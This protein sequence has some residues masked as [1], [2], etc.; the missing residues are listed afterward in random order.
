MDLFNQHNIVDISSDAVHEKVFRVMTKGYGFESDP[1]SLAIETLCKE[2]TV[3][4]VKSMSSRSSVGNSRCSVCDSP[5]EAY[6]RP[7]NKG[8]VRALLK[9]REAG[10]GPLHI[11]DMGVAGGDFTKLK[12]WGLIRL[13][14]SL[15]VSQGWTLTEKGL[16][17]L[18]GEIA[19]WKSV[20]LFKGCVIGFDP[21][22]AS[23]RDAQPHSNKALRGKYKDKIVLI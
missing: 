15:G 8:N 21:V 4:V 6:K 20:W 12:H 22:T 14:I 11:N 17:F 7:I 19:V 5:L 2:L 13:S 10:G 9:I 18:N 3:Q 16:K 1:R 23:V